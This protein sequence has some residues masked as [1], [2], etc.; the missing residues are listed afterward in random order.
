MRLAALMGRTV[1]E[2]RETMDAE[3]WSKWLAFH[4]LYDL[5][6]GFLVTGQLGALVSHA[7]GGKGKPED[8]APYFQR[9]SPAPTTAPAPRNASAPGLKPFYSFMAGY[10]KERQAQGRPIPSER[11][12]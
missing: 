10:A 7:V 3:E 4:A 2:L 8:F 1:A 12:R 5:P 6:D 11:R 9:E